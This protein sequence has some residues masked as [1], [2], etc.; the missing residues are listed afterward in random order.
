MRFMTLVHSIE[1]QGSPPEELLEA[2]A[3]LRNEAIEAGE[4][5]GTGGLLPTDRGAL[6]QMTEGATTVIDGPFAE[7][8]EVVGGFALWELRS[9]DEAIERAKRFLEL[10]TKYW[11]E[12][13]GRVEVR[14][15]GFYQ[16]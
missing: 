7:S 12:W 3:H 13:R 6:V 9:K 10:H 11:P 14:E 16:L 4:F 2:I 15:F 1:P 8:K 5:L